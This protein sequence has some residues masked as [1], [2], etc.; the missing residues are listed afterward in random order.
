MWNLILP[1]PRHQHWA[2]RERWWI[3]EVLKKWHGKHKGGQ[4]VNPEKKMGTTPPLLSVFRTWWDFVVW[5]KVRM[6]P[7]VDKNL[8]F[9]K[10]IF[11]CQNQT[12][13]IRIF[14]QWGEESVKVV[15]W[16]L[17][18]KQ[19]LLD[20]SASSIPKTPSTIRCTIKLMTGEEAGKED[21]ILMYTWIPG[22]L[23]SEGKK[24]LPTQTCIL[25]LR[26][27]RISLSWCFGVFLA[28]RG[29]D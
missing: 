1:T 4:R 13:L 21:M 2:P 10:N 11:R 25:E 9:F 7:G 29:E 17:W 16:C 12:T 27:C 18:S 6:R 8:G 15:K 20:G 14:V 22:M 5:C 28:G 23:K 3:W 24:P 19:E 26:K